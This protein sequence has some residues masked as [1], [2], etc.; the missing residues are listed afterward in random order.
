ML[1]FPE[2]AQVDPKGWFLVMEVA[3]EHKAG[4]ELEEGCNGAIGEGVS[5]S[6]KITLSENAAF[7]GAMCFTLLK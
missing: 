1:T 6:P 5:N 7:I 3:T 2:L 4:F